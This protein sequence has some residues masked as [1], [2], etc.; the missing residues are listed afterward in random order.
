METISKV[1][2][3][4]SIVLYFASMMV[5]AWDAITDQDHDKFGPALFALSTVLALSAL[6]ILAIVSMWS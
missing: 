6:A 4:A 5:A 3:T 1:L 2:F